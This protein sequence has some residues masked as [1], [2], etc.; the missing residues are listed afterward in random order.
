MLRTLV[1]RYPGLVRLGLRLADA[2]PFRNS[3]VVRGKNN[4]LINEGAYLKGCRI[5]VHGSGNTVRI[6]S[7]CRL[8]GAN[9]TIEGDSN[10]ITLGDYVY[11]NG[12]D[13]Y[14]EDNGGTIRVG[15]HTTFAGAAHLA[16][17]EGRE[18]SVGSRCL[19]SSDVVIR[20]GDSHSLLDLQGSR[21]NPSADVHIG[22]HVW[23]GARA[24][25]LKGVN[26]H[27]DCVVG[28]GAVVTKGTPGPNCALGG[29]PASVVKTDINWEN[30]RI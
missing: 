29:N 12:V 1:N 23:V 20:V 11:A 16:C 5:R 22:D 2:V 9:I 3:R 21:I 30:D 26:I 8:Y 18:C 4:R 14:M 6:G 13:L 27:R 25:I 10:T 15:D 28:T 24:M 17:I 19:F 7:F